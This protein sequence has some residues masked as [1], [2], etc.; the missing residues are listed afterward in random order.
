MRLTCPNC[1]AQYEVPDDVIPAEGRDVQCSNCDTTWF[2]AHPASD[3]APEPADASADMPQTDPTTEVSP[4]PQSDLEDTPPPETAPIPE[5]EQT[6]P[7]PEA[8]EPE[9]TEPQEDLPPRPELDPAIAA[10]L[11]EEVALETARREQDAAA[12]ETQPDLGLDS[13]AASEPTSQAS[14][15][16]TD[17]FPD[18]EEINS[19]L[20]PEEP[21]P[22][23]EVADETP[24]PQQRSSFAR[25]FALTLLLVAALILVYVNAPSISQA[26][27]DLDPAINSY[28]TT[29]DQA[30]LWLDAQLSALLPPPR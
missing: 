21:E 2:Q 19:S 5:P 23:P 12:L 22:E 10:I 4:E 15:D 26:V 16:G 7:E 20:D 24:P 17:I 6:E 8:S 30:R 18:I 1:A 28:V 29:I 14:E 25:G 9:P 13:A 3:P 27:P 11:R